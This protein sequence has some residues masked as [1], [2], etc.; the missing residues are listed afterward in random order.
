MSLVICCDIPVCK[1]GHLTLTGIA[2]PVHTHKNSL[3]LTVLIVCRCVSDAVAVVALC[4]QSLSQWT[5]RRVHCSAVIPANLLL[6]TSSLQ[7]NTHRT[8][9]VR[10]M[11][12]GVRQMKTKWIMYVSPPHQRLTYKNLPNLLPERGRSLRNLLAP[13]PDHRIIALTTVRIFISVLLCYNVNII[14]QTVPALHADWMSQNYFPV[15]VH[16]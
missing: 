15:A 4:C 6:I 5:V 13:P 14:K 9:P 3:T 7:I 12:T 11:E 16:W 1:W 10:R 8:T 2:K